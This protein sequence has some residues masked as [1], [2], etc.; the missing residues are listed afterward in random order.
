MINFRNHPGYAAAIASIDPEQN[1]ELRAPASSPARDK[2]L[3][4]HDGTPL[5][6]SEPNDGYLHEHVIAPYTRDDYPEPT[7]D[8][9]M[10]ADI[11]HTLARMVQEG[12]MDPGAPSKLA[13]RRRK[14]RRRSIPTSW[15]LRSRA[16]TGRWPRP[17]QLPQEPGDCTRHRRV[18]AC[19]MGERTTLTGGPAR[20]R[21][22]QQA[23]ASTPGTPHVPLSGHEPTRRTTATATRGQA[24]GRAVQVPQ[25][26]CR[27]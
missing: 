17:N 7:V 27:P 21:C 14:A 2:E 22:P 4:M 18:G 1:P 24:P 25:G 9:E 15:P 13:W 3:T 19:R 6:G 8:D 16:S 10:H 12:K 23:Q 26:H 5:P 11:G 20:P